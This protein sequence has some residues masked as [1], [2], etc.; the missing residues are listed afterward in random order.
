LIWRSWQLACRARKLDTGCD[1][2]LLLR[3]VLNGRPE[4]NMFK[5]FLNM[6]K[7]SLPR[8]ERV[9]FLGYRELGD[10]MKS[11]VTAVDEFSALTSLDW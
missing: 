9:Q 7:K 1:L 3:Y 4:L 10:R 2:G 5:F 11:L 8:T 6:F